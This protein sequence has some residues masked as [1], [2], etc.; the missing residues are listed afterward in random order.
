[1]S[2]GCCMPGWE[3]NSILNPVSSS[4]VC[5]LEKAQ[6]ECCVRNT[7]CSVPAEKTAGYVPRG[8]SGESLKFGNCNGTR[9]R[10]RP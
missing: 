5:M 1:M 6:S 9:L 10:L 8:G 2:I 7:D 3:W 4:G